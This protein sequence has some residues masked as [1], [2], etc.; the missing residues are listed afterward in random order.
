MISSAFH[1]V[2]KN[3]EFCIRNFFYDSFHRLLIVV[4]TAYIELLITLVQKNRHD[5]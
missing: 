2:R 1:I 3:K 4:F 5:K